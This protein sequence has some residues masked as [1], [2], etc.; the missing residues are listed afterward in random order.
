[1]HACC[2]KDFER[3]PKKGKEEKSVEQR[4]GEQGGKIALRV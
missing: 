3:H 1:M 2:E 4:L